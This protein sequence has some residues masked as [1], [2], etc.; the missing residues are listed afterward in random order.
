MSD[1]K[2]KALLRSKAQELPEPDYVEQLLRDI[3]MRQRSELLKRSPW[4]LLCERMELTFGRFGMGN[5]AYAGAMAA[6]FVAGLCA[7][8]LMT[9]QSVPTM[10]TSGDNLAAVT[11]RS[12][13][14]VRSIGDPIVAT[15]NERP[16]GVVRAEP[17]AGELTQ[18][19]TQTVRYLIDARSFANDQPFNF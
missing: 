8:Q 2:L 16:R 3:H 5:A 6:I 12:E 18:N 11:P 15:T 14:L 9:P 13:P 17:R 4:S 1:E 10:S 19:G 7:V